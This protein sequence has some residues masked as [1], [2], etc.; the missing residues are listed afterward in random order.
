MSAMRK[1]EIYRS[2]SDCVLDARIKLT[3]QKGYTD[4]MDRIMFRLGMDAGQTAL[5][6]AGADDE[7]SPNE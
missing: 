5:R 3:Y 1:A 7:N 2:V 4:E 6:A